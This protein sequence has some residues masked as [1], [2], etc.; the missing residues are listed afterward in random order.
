[1]TDKEQVIIDGVDVSKCEWFKDGMCYAECDL[2]G[3]TDWECKDAELSNCYF[4]QLARKTQECEQKEKEI[5]G[6]HLIID[7]LLEASGYDKHISSAEDFE[8]V[9]KDMDYKLG[10][11][12][13]LKQECEALKSES[14]TMNSL[15]IEQEEE[16]EELKK[17]LDLYKTWYRAKHDDIRNL[18]GSYR[19]ALEEIKEVLKDEIC[20]EC[21]GEEGCKG[22]CKEHQCLNIINKVKGEMD[23]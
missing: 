5:K 20:E 6:L 12:D 1:M 15:I 8:D 16:I 23:E 11:I 21:P 17:E 2:E 10:L 18:L 13:E 9:Y 19:K 4:K 7:R 3:Y 14:F 22:G